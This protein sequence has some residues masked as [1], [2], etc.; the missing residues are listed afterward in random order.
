MWW[1]NQDYFNLK[2]DLI[3]SE[4]L[5]AESAK[6]VTS[7]PPMSTAE[8]LSLAWGHIEPILFD[9]RVRSAAFQIWLNRDFTQWGEVMGG[10][11][12][13]SLDNW[14]LSEGM[15]VYFRKDILDYLGGANAIQTSVTG[16][17]PYELSRIELNPDQTFGQQGS[18][19]GQL[20]V[21][22]GVA[23]APDGS[24]Y[25][26]N[27]LNNRIEHFDAKG[28][29]IKAW[30]SFADVS[31]GAAPGGTFNEP[32]GIAVGPN[33]SVYVADTWNHRVQKFTA[34]GTFVAMWGAPP[35]T[36]TDALSFYGPRA[37]AVDAQGRV[38]I[39]DTGNKRIVILSS[40]GSLLGQFGSVGAGEGELDEPVGLAVDAPGPGVRGRYLEPPRADLRAE[41]RRQLSLHR[42]LRRQR[43]VWNLARHQ[44]VSGGGLRPAH[45]HHRPGQLPHHRV[46]R[47]RRGAGGLGH[48]RRRSEP[49]E[50][51]HRHGDR[52][53]RRPV[54]DGFPPQPA[55]PLHPAQPGSGC[56]SGAVIFGEIG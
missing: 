45:I 35:G 46:Q 51:A 9:P 29:L 19:P 23:A 42:K 21:P 55:G 17:D 8:Y 54:G 33:G 1:H 25:V 24:L 26:A 43:V 41:F 32:W 47:T 27:S 12:G 15:Y 6:H 49:T 30:G 20:S 31:Q 39:A 38:F 44:A 36:T 7:P 56:S 40:D 4:Y 10:N 2:W 5:A 53:C 13:Y 48:V 14:S 16:T 28:N 34:D 11:G 18:Q 37:I 52:S 50:H 22:R 3:D